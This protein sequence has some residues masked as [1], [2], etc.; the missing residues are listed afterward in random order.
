MSAA[1]DYTFKT[2]EPSGFDREQPVEFKDLTRDGLPR[3]AVSSS[4]EETKWPAWRT[5]LLILVTCGSF[6]ASVALWLIK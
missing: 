1:I 5:V 6:W 3:C 4:A 2:D